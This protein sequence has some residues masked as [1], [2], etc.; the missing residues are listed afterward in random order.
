[1]KF[2]NTAL[3]APLPDL[4]NG[5]GPGS[6]RELE[7]LA[8]RGTATGPLY[9]DASSGPDGTPGLCLVV[10]TGLVTKT[11][12]NNGRPGIDGFPAELVELRRIGQ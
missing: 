8:F 1:V 6:G 5:F 3:G 9:T 11:L 4:V 2:K 12:N 7:F 10:Q